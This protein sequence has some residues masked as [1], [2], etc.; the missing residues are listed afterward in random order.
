MTTDADHPGPGPA[1]RFD[2]IVVLDTET[3]GR[4]PSADV[5]EIAWVV[6]DEHLEV[7][8]EVATLIDPGRPIPA[9]ATEV[10]GITDEMVAGA[11]TFEAFMTDP[12]SSPFGSGS[13]LVIGHNVEFDYQHIEAYVADGTTLCTLRLARHLFPVL[14]SHTLQT[15]VH[16]CRLGDVQTHRAAADV[17][18]TLRLARR[19]AADEGGSLDAL[20]AVSPVALAEMRVP[21]GDYRREPV[22]DLTAEQVAEI[23]D[24]YGDRLGGDFAAALDL[25]HP[26]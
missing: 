16:H 26:Q 10:H 15:L 11:P 19:M 7:L 3:T 13:T 23:R 17:E 22:R 14:G 18:L 24:R 4:G 1:A 9:E 2:H 6:I 25:H 21:F 20:L 12:T 5:V 8:D